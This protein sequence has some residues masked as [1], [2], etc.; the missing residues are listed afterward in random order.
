M[1]AFGGILSKR[2]DKGRNGHSLSFQEKKKIIVMTSLVVL[3][4]VAE[5]SC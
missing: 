5:R 2:G 1:M 4:E 3:V